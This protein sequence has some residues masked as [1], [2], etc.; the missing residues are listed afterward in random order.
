M[1]GFLLLVFA[2]L[3]AVTAF[4][5]L[6]KRRPSKS[7]KANRE[8]KRFRANYVLVYALMMGKAYQCSFGMRA[9]VSL[10]LIW[11]LQKLACDYLIGCSWRLAPRPICVRPIPVLWLRPGRHRQA[12]HW[13][14]CILHDLWDSC[15]ISGRQIVRTIPTL[16]PNRECLHDGLTSLVKAVLPVCPEWFC[17]CLAHATQ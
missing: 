12:L 8:F 4:L 16:C 13:R 15:R 14:V 9:L 2:S 10:L 1:E 7:D 5:E 17:H 3:A 6:F 11:P